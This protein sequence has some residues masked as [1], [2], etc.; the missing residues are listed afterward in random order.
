M[1]VAQTPTLLPHLTAIDNVCLALRVVRGISAQEAKERSE[2]FALNLHLNH[3][4]LVSYPEQLSSGEAQRVQLLR[5]MVLQPDF[6]LLDEITANIDPQTTKE[7][8]DT[9]WLLRERSQRRQTIVI[10][11]HV[12]EF[13]QRFADR[14]VFIH[15]GVVHEQG[16]AAAFVCSAERQ[17]TRQF[18][19]QLR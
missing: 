2:G 5:A 16:A 1:Y 10:V 15:K 11:T 17:Q 3:K 12:V 9:L 18:L 7:V 6:L 14:I 13:A 4:S 19:S 8:I